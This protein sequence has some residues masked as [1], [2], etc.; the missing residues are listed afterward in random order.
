MNASVTTRH[1][2]IFWA[3]IAAL[4][5]VAGLMLSSGIQELVHRWSTEEEYG[6]GFLLPFVSAYFLWLKLP[7]IAAEQWSP[8]WQGPA[9]AL[10][11]SLVFLI[12]EVSA[13]YLLVHY[14]LVLLM[15]GVGV[16]IVGL[17][18][19]RHLL[20]PAVVLLFAIPIPYFIQAGL[21]GGLQLVS[22]QLGVM[23]IEALG[24]AVFLDGNVIDLGVYKLQVV[25]AC[26]GLRYLFPLLSLGFICAFLFRVSLWKRV[27]VVVST[28]PITI[29]M[30]S[31]RI[32]VTGVLVEYHGIEMA[33]GFMH[34]FEG[35]S[36]F[37]VCLAV[38]FFEMWLL[39]R[40]G[41]DRAPF[42]QVFGVDSPAG[43]P[44]LLRPERTAPLA[45]SAV[46]VCA[47]L[48]TGSAL[49]GRTEIVP[50]RRPLVTFPGHLDDWRGQSVS[51]TDDV[52]DKLKLD[53]Y[54]LADYRGASERVPV[55]LYVAWYES[56]RTGASPHSPRVC[57]PGGGWE[58]ASLRRRE[59]PFSMRGE[60]L[61]YNRA[62]IRKGQEQ[63]LVY[64][65]F[66]QR[67]RA[68]ANEYVMK[69]YL[70]RDAVLDRRSDGALVRL[71]TPVLPGESLETADERLTR[72]A[73][74]VIPELPAYIPD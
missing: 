60:P 6:H 22:S 41:R 58:I 2:G 67:G 33:E 54:L 40:I 39:S 14:A 72:F 28:V 30:N 63:Q 48:A 59:L 16:S 44:R 43:L 51:M 3:A 4:V 15:F 61:R 26:S 50:P 38:L 62:I 45:V 11:A 31:L 18:P 64:Y 55:N 47:A 34:D 57:I 46:I 65:W 5:V 69:W 27:L 37:A 35:W 68:I 74:Q 56:Q 17:R 52:L 1:A 9:I 73:Y 23:L 36:I 42:L 8:G 53:D 49:A 66:Q 24:I 70:F 29:L 20:A 21:S 13:L 10:L 71:V 12:G 25:D 19:A 32:G 7:E